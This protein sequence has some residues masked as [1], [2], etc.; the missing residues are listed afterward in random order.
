MTRD[1]AA[2]A[3]GLHM[4]SLQH[5]FFPALGQVFMRAYYRAFVASPHAVAIVAFDRGTPVGFVVGAADVDAHWRWVL[6][7][8][9]GALGLAAAAGMVRHPHAARTFVRTRLRRYARAALRLSKS[10][11][12]ASAHVPAAASRAS[13]GVLAHI[14]VAPHSRGTGVGRELVQSFLDDLADRGANRVELVTSDVQ[15][16]AAAFYRGLG[17]T[18]DGIRSDRAGNRVHAFSKMIDTP[19][20][21]MQPATRSGYSR[22]QALLLACLAALGTW[23]AAV[24]AVRL[25]VPPTTAVVAAAAPTLVPADPPP[26]VQ[27]SPSTT[28]ALSLPTPRPTA[29]PTSTL[30]APSVGPLATEASSTRQRWAPAPAEVYPDAKLAAATV[31][32][33]ITTFAADSSAE[34]VAA[35]LLPGEQAHSLAEVIRP[36]F[37]AGMTSEGSVRYAQLG[38]LA[39][40]RVSVMVVVDRHMQLSGSRLAESRT[41]D[42]R[43]RQGGDGSWQLEEVASIGGVPVERPADL[44]PLAARVTDD[45]RIELPDSARWDIYRGGVDQRL[46]QTMADM[47]DIAPYSVAVISSGH[48]INVFGRS[49]PSNHTGGRGV[50]VYAVDGQLVVDQHADATSAYRMARALYEG[51]VEELGSPWAFT[52]LGT[53]RSFTD[54]V[55]ADHLH[56]AYDP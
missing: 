1:T 42:V 55:H 39:A 11:T 26:A 35:D 9:W 14:A 18:S 8:R 4:R 44:D 3:A 24:L 48:P 31:A 53:G 23:T 19:R 33:R 16:G 46:L 15:G 22:L 21:Q 2:F 45:P 30:E 13:T 50:D 40:P 47:A 49:H 28:E 29:S 38:G 17:W 32:E 36:L 6:R 12:T 20:H 54:T 7:R 51:D 52:D 34:A 56:V 43:L 37:A 41:I 25:I 10:A 27:P 5:G